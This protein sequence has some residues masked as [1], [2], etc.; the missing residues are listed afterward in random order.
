MEQVDEKKQTSIVDSLSSPPWLR[1]GAAAIALIFLY[2]VRG[3]LPPF[4]IGAGIAYLLGPAIESAERRWS[5]PR[6]VAVVLFYLLFLG[7]PI[8]AFIIFGARFFHETRELLGHLPG[9]VTN[10]IV[11]AFGPGP[12]YLGGPPV[13]PNQIAVD[14]VDSLRGTVGTPSQAIHVAS[15]FVEFLLAT[16]LSLVVSV[17]FLIDS[18]RITRLLIGLVPPRNRGQVVEVSEEVHRTLARYLRGE[19]FLIGLVAGVSFIGLGLGFHLHYALPVAVVT[20]IVEIVPFIGP[21][22]AASI[23]A[24]I[25]LSQGGIA[26]ATGVIIFYIILRQIEDQIVMPVV[27]GRAVELHPLVVLFAVLAGGALAGVIG[28]LLAVPIA[29]AIK[30]VLQAWLSFSADTNVESVPESS[31]AKRS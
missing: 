26:L 7:P 29:A 10:L 1:W 8:L 5:M 9:I 20:G 15:R 31:P 2:L 4:L 13:Y 24:L 17:Y 6:A 18:N 12:Y 16:F 22:V 21:V 30:V 3:I 19:L 27:V 28:T 14:L 23:A 11:Q 25:A